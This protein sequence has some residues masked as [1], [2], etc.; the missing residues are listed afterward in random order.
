MSRPGVYVS[1]NASTKQGGLVN[2][3]S[4]FK[5]RT[6]PRNQ[7]ELMNIIETIASIEEVEHVVPTYFLALSDVNET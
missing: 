4:I 6:V 3:Y 2:G 7:S 5:N 1:Y